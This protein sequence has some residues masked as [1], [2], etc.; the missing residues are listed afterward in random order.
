[1][2]LFSAFF[3]W[4]PNQSFANWW[5]WPNNVSYTIKNSKRTINRPSIEWSKKLDISIIDR[6]TN[7]VIKLT[8]VSTSDRKYTINLT[9]EFL[10]KYLLSSSKLQFVFEPKDKEW[11]V[12]RY[13]VAVNLDPRGSKDI[14]GDWY[15]DWN[16]NEVL[17]NWYT[18]EKNNAYTFAYK[19]WLT[20]TK[21]INSADM[22]WYIT[23]A[24]LAKM[25]TYF[26]KNVLIRFPDQTKKC[27]FNDVSSNLDN[28]YG[29]WITESCKLGIMWIWIS[30]FNPNW[31]VTRAEFA[32]TLSRLLFRTDDWDPYYK[33]HLKNL[34]NRQIIS[35]TNPN[36]V[37][38]RGSI[39]LMFMR[40][41]LKNVRTIDDMIV[42]DSS[43]SDIPLKDASL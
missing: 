33:P 10:S 32:T 12:L 5:A 11:K 28:Q 24:Q 40:A 13:D 30:N 15:L 41:A 42:L 18:R 2:L 35:D 22:D 31:H 7:D 37:E 36:I 34:K 23:R 3:I 20:T 25:M 43:S 9:K 39:L 4:L 21:S 8:T 26:A 14:E 1:M 19:Y 17:S 29:N 27:S 38:K 6:F 16:Q